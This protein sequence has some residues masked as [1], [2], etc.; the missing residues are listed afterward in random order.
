M[1]VGEVE[2][3][4]ERPGAAEPTA[5]LFVGIWPPPEVAAVL[6]D[7]ERPAL[8]AVRWVP[9]EQLH[10][11]VAFLGDVALSRLD[12]VQ[13]ALGAAMARAAAPPEAHLGP[14]SRRVGR[15]VLWVPVAGL[16]DLAGSVRRS[17]G[18]LL[19]GAGLDAPF[20]G[21]LTL[22]RARGRRTIPAALAG[23][24]IEA[25]WRVLA[26]DLVRS[27]LDPAGARYTRFATVAVPW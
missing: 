26:A 23:A 17:L 1:S 14:S 18:T 7:L 27:E 9:P 19:P 16:D 24:P 4:R 13:A 5:R 3:D 2:G 10:V 6:S 12:D 25:S 8:E 15:S 22:A 21:H 11:T 20:E